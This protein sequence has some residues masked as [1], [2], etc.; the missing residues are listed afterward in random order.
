MVPAHF[1]S[2]A[3]GP[4]FVREAGEFLK[5]QRN[6]KIDIPREPPDI[7]EAKKSGC[8]E[9]RNISGKLLGNPV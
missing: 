8:T 9:D 2:P 3:T 1:L 6:D 5:I 4:K 7:N